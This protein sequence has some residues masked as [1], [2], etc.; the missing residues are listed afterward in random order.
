ML[1][2]QQR[3]AVPGLTSTVWFLRIVAALAIPLLAAATSAGG[4][5]FVFV[6]GVLISAA[7]GGI[8]VARR[9]AQDT[10]LRLGLPAAIILA[11]VV[12][13]LA[14]LLVAA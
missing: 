10:R 3:S 11:E 7:L 5:A 12:L 2:H 6:C 1:T 14:L 9:A 8:Y 13:A 4:A